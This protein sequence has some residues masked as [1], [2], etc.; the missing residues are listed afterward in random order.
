[1]LRDLGWKR[2]SERRRDLRLALFYKI[3]HETVAV[4]ADTIGL[5]KADQRTRASNQYKF[6]VVPSSTPELKYSFAV[7]T[8]PEWNKLPGRIAESKSLT[9]FKSEL[10]QYSD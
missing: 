2:L 4:P 8:V 5:I 1:M 6:K 10:A 7:R 3:V 9:S